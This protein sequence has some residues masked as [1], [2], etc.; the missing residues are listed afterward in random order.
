VNWE[1]VPNRAPCTLLSELGVS[2]ATARLVKNKKKIYSRW[3]DND[4]V[5][6][7]LDA[8]LD[9]S[10]SYPYSSRYP[11]PGSTKGTVDLDTQVGTVV[12]WCKELVYFS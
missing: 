6:V 7:E 11:I 1:N 10:V 2:V 3:I 9:A 4:L 12:V 8:V 5:A